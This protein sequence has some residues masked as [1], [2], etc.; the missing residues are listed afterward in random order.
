MSILSEDL[1]IVAKSVPHKFYNSTFFVTGA[2]G[3]IGSILIKG[4]L[5]CNKTY[6]SNIKI[7]AL[8]R[9]EK[10]AFDIFSEYITDKLIFIKNDVTSQ[11]KC[12]E[13]IDYIIHG[14][15]QTASKEMI[16]FP[17]E[18]SK[19]SILGTFNIFDFAIEKKVKA[20]LFL[21]SMEA[22]GICNNNTTRLSE[23]E[24]G[25]ID[26]S[27]IRS[28]YSESKR[29][30]ELLSK[31]YSSEFNI[32]FINARL[33]QVFGAGLN[34]NENRVFAQFVKSAINNQDIILHTDGTSWGN[35]C[36][37]IDVIL[38]LFNILDKGIA[39]ETYTVVNEESSMMIK[40]MAKLIIDLSSSK[41]KLKFDIPNDN[42][43]GYA[44]KTIM[45]LSSAKLE[46]LGW[47]PTVNL[48][49]MFNRLIISMKESL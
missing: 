29:M 30:C 6:N 40:E 18:T 49:E 26:L 47:K 39:G 20:C 37:T 25:K 19:T 14:A 5:T 16:S 11:I 33:A 22:F 34:K 42:T 46:S 24:L 43:F 36:Y 27:N 45:K 2:T 8:I 32:K 17:V 28:C 12:S 15:A 48:K 38:A 1:S 23:T 35:Y 44:P 10:K 4:L 9:N 21:S 13:S 3:L 7:I 31:C 41:S